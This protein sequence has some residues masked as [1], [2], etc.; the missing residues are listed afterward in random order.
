LSSIQFL[1][2]GRTWHVLNQSFLGVPF[3]HPLLYFG[4][5]QFIQRSAL[6]VM[7]QPPLPPEPPELSSENPETSKSANFIPF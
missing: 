5:F 1:I 3:K 7:K 6:L 4:G 2:Y